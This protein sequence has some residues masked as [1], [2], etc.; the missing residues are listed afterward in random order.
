[1]ESKIR[2]NLAQLTATKLFIK[3][4]IDIS[5]GDFYQFKNSFLGWLL[6]L[7][8]HL[9]RFLNNRRLVECNFCGWE[10]NRFYPH[11]TKARSVPDEKCPKCHSIPRYRLLQAFLINK[12]DFYNKKLSVLEIGPNRSLQNVLLNNPNFEYISIDLKSP[13]AMYHMNITD[14]KFEENKFEFIFCIGV[15]QFVENDLKG[16]AEMLR[17]LKPGGQLLF[18]SGVDEK[19]EKTLIYENP[20]VKNSFAVRMYGQDIINIMQETGFSVKKYLSDDYTSEDSK[21][22]YGLSSHAMYLLEK[23]KN[24]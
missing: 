21:V 6:T 23:R 13:Q 9:G 4:F 2:Q 16:F 1:M 11:V 18:A 24:V 8:I 20:S 12:L 19:A 10:G 22:S 17:V 5:K 3:M 14:L 15:M 7:K